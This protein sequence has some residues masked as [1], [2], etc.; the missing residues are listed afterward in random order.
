MVDFHRIKRIAIKCMASKFCAS[1]S[2]TNAIIYNVFITKYV[3][4]IVNTLCKNI[5]NPVVFVNAAIIICTLG[6]HYDSH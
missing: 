1:K 6:V 3:Y 5:V 2:F 4:I